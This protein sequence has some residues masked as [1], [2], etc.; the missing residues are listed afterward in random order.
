MPA[1]CWRSG[2]VMPLSPRVTLAR[3][4][5]GV[6]ISSTRRVAPA[7][8]PASELS[9]MLVMAGAATVARACACTGCAT[10]LAARGQQH[11]RGD[12]GTQFGLHEVTSEVQG[13]TAT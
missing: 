4:A 1:A 5:F 12:G 10:K 9:A 13:M 6:A 11:H 3:L 8:K 2:T 7:D